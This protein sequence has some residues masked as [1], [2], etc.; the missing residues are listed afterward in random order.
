MTVE[1]AATIR[2]LLNDRRTRMVA[3]STQPRR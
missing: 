2:R 1:A 3:Q